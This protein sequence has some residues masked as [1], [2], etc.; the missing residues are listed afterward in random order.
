MKATLPVAF[1][2]TWACFAAPVRAEPFSCTTVT[3]RSADQVVFTLEEPWLDHVAPVAVRIEP[4]EVLCV[5]GKRDRQG[6][7]LKL[8]VVESARATAEPV[9]ELRLS[10]GRTTRLTVRHS[11]SKVLEGRAFL[12]SGRQQYVFPRHLGPVAPGTADTANW[13]PSVAAVLVSDLTLAHEPQPL[14]RAAEHTPEKLGVLFGLWG[15]ER[16]AHL[17]ALN[18]ALA[19]DGFS[20]VPSVLV[21]GGFD[22]EVLFHRLRGSLSL[23]G[24]GASAHHRQTGV[25]LETWLTE[26]GLLLGYDFLQY[27]GLSLF[28]SSGILA[29]DLR[30][31]GRT[32]GL[33]LF[34]RQLRS[35]ERG[36]VAWSVVELPL[37]L[38][39]DYWLS[40]SR[41]PGRERLA[42]QLSTRVGWHEQLSGGWGTDDGKDDRDLRGPALDLSGPRARMT[43]GLVL[44]AW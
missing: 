44:G 34:E 23:G 13:P 41:R 35:W 42:L 3:Q 20:A 11:T 9:V 6:N 32:A 39:V 17:D 15:G 26:V 1:T 36:E 27:E 30:L 40:L 28:A 5:T 14:A 25:E 21:V 4:G 38:G 19:A 37:E 7:L 8:R 29:G 12:V 18:A 10:R 31:D 2:L 16:R 24:G 33:T 22:L 43:V